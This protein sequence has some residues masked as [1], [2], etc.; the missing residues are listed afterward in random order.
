MVFDIAQLPEWTM[1]LTIPVK[2][3]AMWRSARNRDTGWFS[4]FL[5]L[6]LFCVPEILYLLKFD[7][8]RFK[9]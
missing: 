6:N 4:L 8:A 2:G 5:L 1:W 3:Y 9:L 7:N